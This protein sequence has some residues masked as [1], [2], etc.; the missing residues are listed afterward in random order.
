MRK[1]TS[2]KLQL[3]TAN[4][5]DRRHRTADKWEMTMRK[6]CTQLHMKI[7]Q[8]SLNSQ[9]LLYSVFI[10]YPKKLCLFFRLQ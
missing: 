5:A 9:S 2:N 7:M 3:K 8:F 6:K 4:S 1:N 10:K